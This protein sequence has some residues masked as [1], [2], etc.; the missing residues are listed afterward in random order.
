MRTARHALGGTMHTNQPPSKSSSN[1][2][3]TPR[4]THALASHGETSAPPT[5]H[6]S[7]TT[8][9][10][11][12]ATLHRLVELAATG[13]VPRLLVTLPEAAACLGVSRAHLYR[14][15]QHGALHPVRCGEGAVRIPV[16]ELE[17]YVATLLAT[18]AEEAE[19]S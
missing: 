11:L 7:P 17:R 13:A 10:D 8:T 19:R 12:A 14:L 9:P 4:Q 1:N 5:P 6:T 3:S 15:I 2:Q 16:S 18:E